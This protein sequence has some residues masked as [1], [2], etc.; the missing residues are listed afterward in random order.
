MF[1]PARSTVVI[2]VQQISASGFQPYTL[3]D[4]FR[5]DLLNTGP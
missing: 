4:D 1:T 3:I 5:F 2:R